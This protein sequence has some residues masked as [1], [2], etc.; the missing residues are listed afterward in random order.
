MWNARPSSPGIARGSAA[1]DEEVARPER[2]GERGEDESVEREA[3]PVRRLSRSCR[4]GRDAEEDRP[5]VR[6]ADGIEMQPAEDERHRDR[7][8]R[9]RA[10]REREMGEP[11]QA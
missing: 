9:E 3:T 11:A 2:D 1:R 10:E 8:A 5:I 4:A 6:L 7:E